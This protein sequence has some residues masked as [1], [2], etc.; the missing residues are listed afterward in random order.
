MVNAPVIKAG[1]IIANIIWY[2][3]NAYKGIL[4]ELNKVGLMDFKVVGTD[5]GITAIQM[6]IKHRGGFSRDIFDAALD[7]ARRGR[8]VIMDKMKQVMSK[9]NEKLSDLVPK[10]VTL[11]I[12]PDKIGAVI[13]GGGKV[14]REIIEKTGTQIDIESD[15]LVKI[16]AAPTA[17]LDLA[18]KW[19]KTLSGQIEIGSYFNGIIRK[20]AEFGMFVELV[21]GLDGLVHVSN[22][23]RDQQ[24]TFSTVYKQNDVVRVKVLDYDESTGRVSL[25]IEEQAKPA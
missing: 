14:I 3:K 7:Q 12:N 15:G 1:V 21:P 20:I 16:Y 22:I 11:Q 25:R 5:N 6:D 4:T 13:G 8:L 23:P 24:R 17:D 9:P 10:V 19:V 18:V 2:A